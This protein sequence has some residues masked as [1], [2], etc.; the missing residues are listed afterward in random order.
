MHIHDVEFNVLTRFGQDGVL[1]F[2]FNILHAVERRKFTYLNIVNFR[3]NQTCNPLVS[4]VNQTN[5]HKGCFMSCLAPASVLSL[6]TDIKANIVVALQTVT[7]DID[8]LHIN[9]GYNDFWY[10]KF[11]LDSNIKPKV[12]CIPY[13]R[14]IPF[15]KSLTVPFTPNPRHNNNYRSC[16]LKALCSILPNYFIF[17]CSYSKIVYFVRADIKGYLPDIQSTYDFN[18]RTWKL[19]KDKFWV[20]V[21]PKP[22]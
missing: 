9:H 8:L 5:F 7:S 3:A 19:I 14:N 6:K 16:S 1:S 11:V 10:L 21:K 4:M 2:I 13:N 22:I 20:C 17:G 15:T 18:T 12:I